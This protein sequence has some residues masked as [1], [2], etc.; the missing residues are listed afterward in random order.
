M[1]LF[2]CE[3]YEDRV[4]IIDIKQENKNTVCFNP[5]VHKGR[6]GPI[7]VRSLADKIYSLNSLDDSI[8]IVSKMDFKE[9]DTIFLS[10]NPVDLICDS[11][12]IF[13]CCCDSDS[14]LVMDYSGNY[15]FL[16]N[17]VKFP[18]TLCKNHNLIAVGGYMFGQ[19]NVYDKNSFELTAS[20]LVEGC[21]ID[22]EYDGEDLVVAYNNYEE[23]QRG[24]LS[25]FKDY[26]KNPQITLVLKDKISKI[27]KQEGKIYIA[28]KCGSILCL[29]KGNLFTWVDVHNGIDDFCVVDGKLYISPMDVAF[30]EVYSFLGEKI[31]EIEVLG[32]A[33][34]LTRLP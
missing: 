3:T 8:S 29:Y 17:E 23:L 31:G 24:C 6:I 25:I 5:L 14:F 10:Q 13:T 2:L 30:I 12:Y 33:T 22:M 7:K 4:E 19:V 20:F 27:K 28:L 1:L 9:T 34:S 21:V 18:V 15:V 11:K 16:D 26:S 32:N